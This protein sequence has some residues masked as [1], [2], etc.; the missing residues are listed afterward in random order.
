MFVIAGTISSFFTLPALIESKFTSVDTLIRG[1]SDFHDHFVFPLQLW[2]SPWGFGGS[3][4]GV[5][6]GMSF[7]IGKIHVFVGLVALLLIR[8]L[9]KKQSLKPFPLTLYR[10]QLAILGTSI[11]MMLP[12]SVILWEKLPGLSYIQYPWRL[13]TFTAFSISVLGGILTKATTN[14]I[15]K[16]IIAVTVIGGIL[17]LN[18]KLFD[19]KY[20]KDAVESEYISSEALRFTISKISDEYLPKEFIR[21]TTQKETVNGILSESDSLH[22]EQKIESVTRNNYTL[23]SN[24]DQVI[25]ANLAFFPGWNVFVDSRETE[26]R[27]YSGKIAFEIPQGT[28]TVKLIFENTQIRTVANAISLFGIFLLGYVS[29]G[30]PGIWGG[31][32][33]FKTKKKKY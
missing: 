26:V 27:N 24:A 14:N 19:V 32:S 25:V 22:I 3:A 30:A 13:L 1:G 15:K 9:T 21:P 11:F 8:F 10:I 2:D 33:F 31:F 29:F 12:I 20:I 5:L 16:S 18:L 7:R 4:K 6:D 28:H 23:Q 17:L